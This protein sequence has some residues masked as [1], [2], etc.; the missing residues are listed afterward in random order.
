[1]LAEDIQRRLQDL[2]PEIPWAHL[3]EFAPGI[4]S[5]TT[6]SE[7][8][9][10]KAVGLR[11]I[12][13]LLLDISRSEV[14]GHTLAGK[15][16]LDLG[17]GEGG[18]SI[19]FARSGASVLGIEGRSLYLARARFAAEATGTANVR[20][21]QG[22]VRRLPS[23]IEPFDVVLASGILHHLGID[24]FDDMAETLG[25]Q[26][27]DLLLIYLHISTDLSVTNHRLQGP[28]KT[29]RGR[30]GHLFREHQDNAT[31]QEKVQQVRASLDNTFS[32]WPREESLIEALRSVG[33]HL[34]LK[35]MAPHVFG[36]EGASYRPFLLAKKRPT[37]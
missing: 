3:F 6:K 31:L 13:D 8:F 26:T 28:V 29:R 19:Q 21:E 27:S 24:D 36:W 1:M 20:F 15:R 37:L 18:H 23:D 17:C 11:R 35:V 16:V 5:V 2:S 9:Y 10:K 7:Q 34:I 25:R 30:E 22:D 33:F 12:G 32:F 4:V 14:R